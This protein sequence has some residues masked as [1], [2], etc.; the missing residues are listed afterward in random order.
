[1]NATTEDEI[2][3]KTIVSHKGGRITIPIEFRNKLGIDDNTV[4]HLR[5]VEDRIKISVAP[6]LAKNQG[7]REYQPHEVYNFLQ[8]GRLSQE[9]FEEMMKTIH[10][11]P[12]PSPIPRIFL[13]ASV[14]IAALDIEVNYSRLVLELCKQRKA[15]ALLTEVVIHET[16]HAVEEVMGAEMMVKF[17]A[18]LAELGAE[19]LPF[20]RVQ[21]IEMVDQVLNEKHSHVLSSAW[22]GGANYILTL[23]RSSILPAEKRKIALP[24]KVCTPREFIVEEVPVS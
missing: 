17:Y 10:V 24:T 12:E 6:R 18:E 16:E 2:L 9:A 21:V 5:I 20:P 4:L 15:K 13:D 7:L 23:D 22:A 8:M 1:M 3:E 14:L 19:I 11:W